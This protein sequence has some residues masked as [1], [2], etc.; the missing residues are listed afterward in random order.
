MGGFRERLVEIEGR[1][2][3]ACARSGRERASVQ[4]VAVSKTFGPDAVCEAYELGLSVMGESRVQ[5]ARQKMP[6]CP[7]AIRWHMIGHLQRNKAA[8]AA[9]LFDMVQSVDSERLYTALDEACEEAG[10]QMRV[11]IE[12]NVS[13]EGSKC[14]VRP[15]ELERLVNASREFRRLELVGLMTI[16]AFTPDPADAR[17]YFAALRDL[18]DRTAL[19]TGIGLEHLSM[20][21]S[22]DFEVA[23]EE[24][25][26]LVR[27]GTALFGDRASGRED[28]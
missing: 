24:G 28:D 25:S 22:H 9:R 27:I 26:T 21:M 4:L 18:R 20:G 15:D 6:Q 19:A 3:A 10:R 11:C 7:G 2:S 8:E 5:E 13:G 14:G 1:M 16:P 17:R 23:I 12:V